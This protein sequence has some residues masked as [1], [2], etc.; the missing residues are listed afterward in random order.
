MSDTNDINDKNSV[1]IDNGN[2][3]TND[4]L[5]FFD[6]NPNQ[7]T[8]QE[9]KKLAIDIADGK[10]F[11]DRH[12]RDINQLSMVFMILALMEEN[13]Y[14]S[15]IHE[16]GLIYEYMSEAG[17]MSINGMPIFMSVRRLSIEEAQKVDSFYKEYMS[18][19]EG[20]LNE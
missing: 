19:K 17:P 2:T 13:D 7:K 12:L 3:D 10:I 15:F 5:D 9:L 16:V 8:D 4:E 20:F 14:N 18:F 1:S 6:F 11:T